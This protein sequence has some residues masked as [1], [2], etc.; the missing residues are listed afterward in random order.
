MSNPFNRLERPPVR[1]RA[2]EKPPGKKLTLRNAENVWK[3]PPASYPLGH[4]AT[5]LNFKS[6]AHG[7]IAQKR[8]TAVTTRRAG[9][10]KEAENAK[11]K[12]AERKKFLKMI[13][14]GDN[15]STENRNQI[16]KYPNLASELMKRNRAVA[17]ARER[18]KTSV[19]V[20]INASS[21][22]KVV[23]P[24]FFAKRKAAAGEFLEK[25]RAAAKQKEAKRQA[26]LQVEQRLK[27]TR[28][29]ARQQTHNAF[30]AR[31]N[32]MTPI[33]DNLIKTN[34]SP[35]NFI[36]KFK[37]FESQHPQ[38]K[39]DW[40]SSLFANNL[41][42]KRLREAYKLNNN[43][44]FKKAYENADS[45]F[46]EPKN[47]EKYNARYRPFTALGKKKNKI[48]SL[49]NEILNNN[50]ASQATIKS[51][52][53]STLN[54]PKNFKGWRKLANK[55]KLKQLNN[56]LRGRSLGEVL[57]NA[58]K[59]GQTQEK[60]TKQSSKN[61]QTRMKQQAASTRA[62]NIKSFMNLLGNPS[63]TRIGPL[64]RRRIAQLGNENLKTALTVFNAKM[65]ELKQEKASAKASARANKKA[66]AKPPPPSFNEA[67]VRNALRKYLDPSVKTTYNKAL[68][69]AML[70]LPGLNNN[71]KQEL[72][73]SQQSLLRRGADAFGRGAS[74][75]V[76]GAGSIGRN[77]SSK[78][79]ERLKKTRIDILKEI[80][81]SGE[82]PVGVR[83]NAIRELHS[84]L[85]SP[86]I[87]Q[88]N[89][90][91]VK[92]FFNELKKKTNVT[93]I[94]KQQ[95]P[96]GVINRLTKSRIDRLMEIISNG[97]T[98]RGNRFDAIQKL[99]AIQESSNTTSNNRNKITSFLS[100]Y[101]NVSNL[102]RG[103]K[104]RSLT[105]RVLGFFSAK[106]A[107][108]PPPAPANGAGRPSG[109]PPA[110]APRQ[111][112]KPV[113][114]PSLMNRIF[115]R[116]P[117]NNNPKFKPV[118]Y[119]SKGKP[120]PP[121]LGYVLKAVTNN[122]GEVIRNKNGKPKLGYYKN[123][124]ALESQ[125]ERSAI[126]PKPRPEGYYG[127][128]RNGYGPNYGPRRN[129]NGARGPNGGIVFKPQITVGAARIGAQTFGGTR[130]GG[131]QM[132]G[133][134][135]RTG[136]TGS[137]TLKTGNT[138][139]T[140]LKTGNAG[141]TSNA[142]RLAVSAPTT[143]GNRQ[144]AATSEQLIRGAGGAEAVEKGIEALRAANGN[145]ARA[146]AASRLPN[147]TF[148]NIYA[149][150]GPVAAKKLI[151][152][153]RRRRTVRG[154][155][156]KRVAHKP[157]KYIKLTPYQFKRLTD[158]IKKNNLRKVLIKEITH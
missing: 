67:T 20:N 74:A 51:R 111:N 23:K 119:N 140:T 113:A 59:I 139:G 150:G 60:K 98:T 116:N 18:K 133:S 53:A 84:I 46:A 21:L 3:T 151:E 15:F 82:T 147:N 77:Y 88:N 48:N 95:P 11:S 121:E 62:A 142:G 85:Q 143:N 29:T 156:K 65:L 22:F 131:Q 30:L 1:T 47:R 104:P 158:H 100:Q 37:N 138:G 57:A 52:V 25:R 86:T 79:S 75:L 78:L 4:A 24:G 136:N 33:M 41:K 49:L 153:R 26:D 93:N 55:N 125:L 157:K 90:T 134:H 2:A 10:L 56:K 94:L 137:T 54:S 120:I 9:I 106:P 109:P 108:G 7:I 39:K 44:E 17:R 117:E 68:V 61:A 154:R 58:G 141:T 144:L 129:G 152:Q 8:L 149:M 16:K 83:D 69:N 72:I 28:T 115:G 105:N 155:S 97:K 118:K 42:A 27:N 80:I 13:M 43:L 135:V 123:K 6:A 71:T 14:N 89:Q 112:A 81:L 73:K 99:L 38:W 64:N 107:A 12:N 127:P 130:V 35:A 50:Q 34:R 101:S 66:A 87:T 122:K 96:P 110:N 31:R 92:A 126:G 145:V 32:E 132:G 91:N 45:V 76:S 36:T 128:R 103:T 5:G 40:E 19:N 124:N 148:T 70:R 146:K 114:G 102:G 63:T